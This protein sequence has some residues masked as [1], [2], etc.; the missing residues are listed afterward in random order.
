[1]MINLQKSL[2]RLTLCW[3][4]LDSKS[5]IF[6]NNY[7][8]RNFNESKEKC[9]VM[10]NKRF[11]FESYKFLEKIQRKP[12]MDRYDIECLIWINFIY[13]NQKFCLNK[14]LFLSRFCKLKCQIHKFSQIVHLHQV[15]LPQ[16][17]MGSITWMDW[18]NPAVFQSYQTESCYFLQCRKWE[19]EQRP[20]YFKSKWLK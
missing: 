10:L 5:F 2:N 13:E 18:T 6:K 7:I 16:D 19:L 20:V 14:F 15:G 9:T 12:I 8:S 1:M 11:F 17:S 3:W 4:T